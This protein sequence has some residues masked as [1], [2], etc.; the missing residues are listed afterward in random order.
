MQL[1]KLGY[2]LKKFNKDAHVVIKVGDSLY[3][4]KKVH[5]KDYWECLCSR[6]DDFTSGLQV[7]IE[8]EEVHQE[9]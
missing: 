5:A 6:N 9:Y 8:L 4:P 7:V 3:T 1:R 2:K